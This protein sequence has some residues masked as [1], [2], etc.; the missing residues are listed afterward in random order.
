LEIERFERI[1]VPLAGYRRT[2][3]N[4]SVKHWAV[5]E[6]EIA[7]VGQAF[8]PKSKTKRRLYRL[9]MK[10]WL[11]GTNP[12]WALHKIPATRGGFAADMLRHLF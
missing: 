6:R 8:A 5:M 1:G 12:G 4:A 9:F 11:N 3:E 2:G 7:R 10:L